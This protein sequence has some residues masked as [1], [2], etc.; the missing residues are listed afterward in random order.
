[1]FVPSAAAQAPRIPAAWHLEWS[2]GHEVFYCGRCWSQTAKDDK[3]EAK[4]DWRANARARRDLLR[5]F[6]DQTVVAVW[7]RERES[8][9][10]PI[11]V[12]SI[13]FLD[14]G[15]TLYTEFG[16]H[17]TQDLF[18]FS[19]IYRCPLRSWPLPS[20]EG[21]SLW[22]FLERSAGLRMRRSLN[23]QPIHAQL[24]AI[25]KMT[26]PTSDPDHFLL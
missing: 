8:R 16:E 2:D 9:P 6:K 3:R 5:P 25:V 19:W 23:D 20:R 17:W 21:L 22:D 15:E 11:R 1:L 24:L 10:F 12:G 18:G 7:A 14:A 26:S 4:P 13:W